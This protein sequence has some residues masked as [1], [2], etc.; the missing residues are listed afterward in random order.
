MYDESDKLII[1][2]RSLLDDDTKNENDIQRFLEKN[3]ELI[4]T[5]SYRLN[6][7]IHHS[8][9]ISKYP[10]GNSYV[11]DLM[12]LTKSTVRWNVV[13]IE[14]ENQQDKIFC[15]NGNFTAKFNHALQQ[16]RGWK[17][18]LND[19]I[20]VAYFITEIS[21]F[22]AMPTFLK[23]PVDFKYLL[24]FGRNEELVNNQERIHLFSEL[25]D[26]T[27]TVITYDSLI[28][29]YQNN[30]KVKHAILSPKGNGNFKIKF[31]PEGLGTS[32]FGYLK[33][34][35]LEISPSIIE[36]LKSEGYEIDKW[37]AGDRLMVNN[38]LTKDT[39]YKTIGSVD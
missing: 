24:V 20:H 34:S 2:Y 10:F 12:Y 23:N 11:S 26:E 6:H 22:I 3:S 9:I 4:P 28:S 35:E 14:L 16:I 37:L 18:Y 33:P 39:F 15:K 25:S 32:L 27:Q 13:F 36:V 30:P 21:K 38:K 8:A 19:P 7:G 17:A 5:I 31:F 1:D 29:I